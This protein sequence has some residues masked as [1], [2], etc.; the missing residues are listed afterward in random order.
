MGLWV[1]IPLIWVGVHHVFPVFDRFVLLVSSSLAFNNTYTHT[2]TY[3]HINM[4]SFDDTI[5]E[6]SDFAIDFSA[7]DKPE[8]EFPTL[9]PSDEVD[10]VVESELEME[11]DSEME[12]DVKD[13]GISPSAV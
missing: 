13:Q 12:M 9:P 2:Y 8:D 4:G 3:T 6:E 11:M 7:F 5:E 10:A 1:Y